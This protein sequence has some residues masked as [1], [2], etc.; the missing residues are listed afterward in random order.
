MNA[1]EYNSSCLPFT[2]GKRRCFF[3]GVQLLSA[4]FL[5]ATSAEH[6]NLMYIYIFYFL[7]PN[8]WLPEF[9]LDDSL[10]RCHSNTLIKFH[11]HSQSRDT[12]FFLR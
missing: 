12:L 1:S 8:I 6:P 5:T 11:G 9:P 7:K 3:I 10:P 4:F 2:P